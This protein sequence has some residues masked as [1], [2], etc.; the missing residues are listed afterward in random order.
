MKNI[1]FTLTVF[2]LLST[3]VSAQ[4]E[5]YI[6]PS[7]SIY[8]N[9]ASTLT[10]SN[11]KLTNNGSFTANDGTVIFTGNA[12]NAGASI[13][14]TGT[15]A[16]KNLTIDK[17]ANNAQINQDV[18]VA[19]NL[20]LVSGG[21]ELANG[22]VNFG[23]TGSLQG[24]TETY[25]V[26][27]AGGEL[28][29]FVT[30]NAPSAVNHANLG[31]VITAAQNLGLTEI[32]RGHAPF[33][34]P[35]GNSILRYF[36][37]LPANNAGLNATLRVNYF[38]AELNGNNENNSIFWRSTNGGVSWVFQNGA[39]S[40]DVAANWVQM[41]GI[42][43][44]SLWTLADEPP[45]PAFASA[46]ANVAVVNSAC[47]DDC[48][49]TG[50]SISAPA[51]TPCP[52]GSTLQYRVNGGA[53]TTTLPAYEQTGPSQF[54]QTRCSCDNNPAVTSPVSS[55]VTTNPGVCAPAPTNLVCNDL[56]TVSLDESC[57]LELNPDMILEGFNAC[58][59]NYLVQIDRTLPLG[60]GPWQPGIL[61]P[62]D[63][64]H[65][66]AVRVVLDANGNGV[67][68]LGEN[69]CWGNI[70]VEDKLPPVF[71]N[72]GCTTDLIEVPGISG[73]F[74]DNFPT[75]NRPAAGTTCGLSGT[76][77]NVFYQTLPFQV[78]TA[79]VYTFTETFFTGDGFGVLYAGSFDPNNPCNN[80]IVA[81]DDD[82][83]NDFEIIENLAVGSYVLV[84]TTFANG[85][86]GDYAIDISPS[87]F[88]GQPNPCA[89]TCADKDG[90][91]SGSIAVPLP[92]VT[93]NCS[94]PTVTKKDVYVDG[95]GCDDAHIYRTWTAT[96]AWGNSAQCTQ[97][98]I[99]SPYDLDDVNVPEDITIEC[100]GCGVTAGTLPC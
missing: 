29:A 6:P 75:F 99:L 22:D 45:C 54:V 77:T 39:Y 70:A 80:F 97:D 68:D 96:D 18:I 61:G 36:N 2:C 78:T 37:I 38:N 41:P 59:A 74:N 26:Y 23:T 11:A 92:T 50:G 51:G 31:A 32:R 48:V 57:S 62:D 7:G 91:L 28:I 95:G 83:N 82:F 42:S 69:S 1:L 33:V 81:S 47:N 55:G 72:C 52:Q 17:N 34:L 24:E 9:G 98:I 30:L 40:R 88:L 4:G 3:V 12:P 25:R 85:E 8:T 89:F 84:Y 19:G 79:G 13:N 76:G 44:F 16:F 94:T 56:V 43:A 60:N 14:G 90:I 10:L 65:T 86:L 71:E 15:T 53:W 93:D 58:Y 21:L 20:T 63:V 46:P 87:V 35:F 49:V 73:S 67:A 5:L 66:Y 64:H 27:G 100:A